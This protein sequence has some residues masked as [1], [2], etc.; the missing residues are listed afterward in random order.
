MRITKLIVSLLALFGMY[1][2]FTFLQK[3]SSESSQKIFKKTN[4]DLGQNK[5][6]VSSVAENVKEYQILVNNDLIKWHVLKDIETGQLRLILIQYQIGENISLLKDSLDR[7]FYDW[8]PRK[9]SEII[10]SDYKEFVGDE[11]FII[12][13]KNLMPEVKK[14]TFSGI[15]KLMSILRKN[16]SLN[17]L[18]QSYHFKD[19]SLQISIGVYI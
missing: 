2:A 18:I 19:D 9:F 13:T 5:T 1:Y 15:N 12:E 14:N 6:K 17:P 3:S 16:Y 4:I 7:I 11:T 10:I 8:E